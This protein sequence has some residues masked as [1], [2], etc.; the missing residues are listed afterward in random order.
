MDINRSLS[1]YL[2]FILELF[3]MNIDFSAHTHAHNHSLGWKVLVYVK[4]KDNPLTSEYT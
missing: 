3:F 1:L 2:N 4:K